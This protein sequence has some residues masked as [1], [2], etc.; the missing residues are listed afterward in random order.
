MNR[1]PKTGRF[2]KGSVSWNKGKFG[3]MGA[4]RTSFT[5]EDIAAKRQIGKVSQGKGELVCVSEET[6]PTRS[7]NGKIYMHHKRV[8]YAKWLMEKT[9]GRKIDSNKEAVFHIDG[10]YTNN[11]ISNLEVITR[12]ELLRRN[13]PKLKK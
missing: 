11:D 6:R 9:L 13:N 12:A 7:R 1:D 4:N 8:G 10:D 3:Y 5:K 2:L